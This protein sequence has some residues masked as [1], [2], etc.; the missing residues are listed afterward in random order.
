[1]KVVGK[2]LEEWAHTQPDSH[3]K[4]LFS[5]SAFNRYYYAAFLIT[6]EML[7]KYKSEWKCTRHAEIPNLLETSF[8]RSVI[9][10]L[11]KKKKQGLMT[12]G[13]VS[14]LRTTLKT[15]TSELAILLRE[16]YDVRVIADY[17]PETVITTVGNTISLKRYKLSS[18]SSW[19]NR[20]DGYCKTIYRVWRDVGLD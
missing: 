7:S 3:K 4:D 5:R 11:E 17:E 14:R 8:S 20:A 19:E 16:A 2:Q 1:M 13:E 6:R 9:N 15:A 18:A 10:Q 12:D